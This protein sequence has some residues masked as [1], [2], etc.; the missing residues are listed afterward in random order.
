MYMYFLCTWLDMCR[1]VCVRACVKQDSNAENCRQRV[2]VS[3]Y[4][5]LF[6]AVYSNTEAKLPHKQRALGSTHS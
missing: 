4:L 1:F 5:R 2:A 3:P 6:S